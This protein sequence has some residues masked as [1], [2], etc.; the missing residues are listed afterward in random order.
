MATVRKVRGSIARK[1]TSAKSSSKDMLPTELN[2]PPEELLDYVIMIYG[3]KSIGKTTLA[4]MLAKNKDKKVLVIML[5][6]SRRNLRIYQKPDYSK[7]DK[8]PTWTTLIKWMDQFIESKEFDVVVFDTLDKLYDLCYAHI[9]KL[10]GVKSPNGAGRNSSGVWKEI[11]SEF[12]AFLQALSESGKG[13][14]YLSHEKVRELE[15]KKIRELKKEANNDNDSEEI[16][17]ERVEPSASPAA[18]RSAEEMCDV[19]MYYG[20]ENRKRTLTV[21]DSGDYFWVGCNLPDAF[22]DPDGEP[23]NQFYVGESPAEAK[24][25][26]L[27]AYN[28]ELRDINYTPPKRSKPV[29]KRPTR[30]RT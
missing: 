21:R 13:I 8:Y 30:R 9:C 1:K 27:A 11:D 28:N 29:K 24:K 19:I 2:E 4:S 5:E 17:I 26:L 25:N 20:Y 18:C 14:I 22:L 15:A 16:K 23:I 12:N 3:R 7:G 6:K 10:N